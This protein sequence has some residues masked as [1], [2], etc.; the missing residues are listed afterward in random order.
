MTESCVAFISGNPKP[1]ITVFQ[2][3]VQRQPVRALLDSSEAILRSLVD[4]CW[5]EDGRCLPELCLVKDA[6]KMRGQG[7]YGFIDLFI[8]SPKTSSGGPIAA[9]ELKNV[10]LSGI[11]KATTYAEFTYA[12]QESL[13]QK[14]MNETPEELLQRDYCYWDKESR[15]FVTKS[16]QTL[17]Q[18]AIGQV[19]R[20][21]QIA[22]L[23]PA[24]GP[25]RGIQDKRVAYH[26]GTNSL[27]GY[28]VMCI[29]GARILTWTAG[30]EE[31]PYVIT[32]VL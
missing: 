13:R 28:V 18:E 9:I 6:M 4:F 17:Q 24:Q 29:G 14:L 21:L 20:Y 19:N 3:L 27:Q 16:I 26:A 30:H 25:S 23:G 5:F 10:T 32:R 31:V 15:S 22:K 11:F 1:F 8:A 12:A 7:R 2:K